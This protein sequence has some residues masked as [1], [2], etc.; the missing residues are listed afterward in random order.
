MER[1]NSTFR[2]VWPLIREIRLVRC[3]ILHPTSRQPGQFCCCSQ[4]NLADEAADGVAAGQFY[5]VGGSC[6]LCVH[7]KAGQLEKET[8]EYKY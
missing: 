5:Y 3:H 1:G 2:S 7:H 8:S 6:V 4:K